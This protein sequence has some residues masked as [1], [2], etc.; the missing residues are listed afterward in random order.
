MDVLKI[1]GFAIFSV[2]II[3][4]I[5]E[6]KPEVALVIAISAGIMIILVAITKISG[7]ITL[8]DELIQKSGINKDFLSIILKVTG[9]AY[10]IEFGKNICVDAGQSAIATK[11]EMAGKIII[12]VLSLPLISSLVTLLTGLV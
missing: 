3:V 6:Q 7:V 8:L 5:K 2:I 12:V 9:I 11:L 4:I 10:I 1:V